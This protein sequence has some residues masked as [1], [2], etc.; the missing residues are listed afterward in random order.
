MEDFGG[1]GGRLQ[2]AAPAAVFERVLYPNGFPRVSSGTDLAHRNSYGG[3][4]T[5]VTLW[6]FPPFQ[7]HPAFL[8]RKIG[9]KFHD[10]AQAFGGFRGCQMPSVD[11]FI[12]HP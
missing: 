2:P 10:L 11:Q 9:P 1:G 12:Q 8:L 7:P 3:R 4:N 6:V 5:L